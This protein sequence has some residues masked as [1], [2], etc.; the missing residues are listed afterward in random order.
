MSKVLL[1]SMPFENSGVMTGD[2][3]EMPPS[4]AYCLGLGYLH[5]YLESKGHEV[6][7]MGL[8][9]VSR[10]K[11]VVQ[12]ASEIFGNGVDYIGLNVLTF[13][14]ASSFSLVEWLHAQAP[15]VKIVM[16]GIHPTICY[17]QILKK[18][19]YIVIIRGE[20]EVTFDELIKE[21]NR[22]VPK[23]LTIDGL[24]LNVNDEVVLTAP[25]QLIQDLDSLPF[26]NHKYFQESCNRTAANMMTSRGC[27]NRCLSGETIID[28]TNGKFKIEDLVGQKPKILTRHPITK[29]CLYAQ[30]SIVDKT[31]ENEPLVRVSFKEGGYIDCTPDHQF[32]T[33]KNGNQSCG[34]REFVKEASEL[35]PGE[36]VR[37]IHREIQNGSYETIVWGRRKREL[38]HRLILE[39]ILGRG[40]T[41][42]ETCHHLDHNTENNIESNLILTNPHDHIVSY[43]PEISQRMIDNNPAKDLPHEFFVELGKMQQGVVRT[44]ESKLNY[45]NSKLGEKNPNYKHGLR[46]GTKSRIVEVNHIV[47]SVTPIEGLQDTYCLEVPGYDWFYAN[48]VL[49]HNCSFCCLNPTAGT[50]VRFRS[51]KNSVDEV[52]YIAKTFPN[53]KFI[54]FCDDAFFTKPSRVI[55]ICNEIVRRNIKLKFVCQ[56]RAKPCTREMALA[57]QRAGFTMV[58]VGMETGDADVLKGTHKNFT[59]DDLVEMYKTF[60]GTGVRIIALEIVGLPG[61]TW[62][63]IENTGKFVQKIQKIN[64]EYYAF[65]N[66]AMVFPGTE[67]SRN[68]VKAGV[69]TDDYWMNDERTPVYTVDHSLEELKDMQE[70]L[71]TWV[72]CDKLFTKKGFLR[73]WH[74]IPT[75]YWYKI[76]HFWV[77]RFITH[78]E[79]W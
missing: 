8:N 78:E 28:T 12:I 11:A 23:L 76:W 77:P 30:T 43:H 46:A 1:V 74:M 13:N 14:R 67:L 66:L 75:I 42:G 56:A 26:P 36:S 10:G 47:E 37:A 71:M 58:T 62:Q 22:P 7:T 53:V 52:E 17:E 38:K 61:E 50:T 72:S 20:G 48:D 3:Y 5:S 45:R 34:T 19:P 32:I 54:Q 18:Y 16:G 59:L 39:S 65:P 29:D 68:M 70:E 41:E 21:W 57:M 6:K 9:H 51:V 4:A 44:S 27:P 73:Q 60:R 49:V 63:S 24:A 79:V 2:K 55:E 33:F 25:R 35:K 31:G 40:L 15:N 69:I 64:Y